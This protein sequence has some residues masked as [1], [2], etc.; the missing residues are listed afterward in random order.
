MMKDN[1][2]DR[3]LLI[4]VSAPSG[5]GKGTILAEILKDENFYYSV[6][7]TTRA[8]REG[9]IDGTNYHFLDRDS[10]KS[11]IENN[12][13]LEYAEY[14]DNFYGTPRK[15][16]E[17][18]LADGR[19]VILEI[20]VQGAMQVRKTCPEAV[21]IFILPP[22]V[23]ELRRRLEKRG[24]EMEATIAKRVAEAASEIKFAEKYDYV[25][26]NDELDR[27]VY[28]LGAIIRAEKLTQKRSKNKID[29]V[30]NNA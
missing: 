9:E 27:A 17:E 14:C 8:P 10:F 23:G 13:M 7:A 29:G 6:S 3:G 12:G 11:L 22:S 18:M 30:L 16:A 28:D 20:E 19:D 2:K 21:L 24:T 26:I 1:G 15:Q 4:V 5:C 25:M